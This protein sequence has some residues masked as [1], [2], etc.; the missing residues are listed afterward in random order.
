[1][2]AQDRF[3]VRVYDGIP[4]LGEFE[5]GEQALVF[6][7][8]DDEIWVPFF[9]LHQVHLHEVLSVLHRV[10]KYVNALPFED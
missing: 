9:S 8:L 7:F 10:E 5:P 1:M 6:E 2:Y 4:S 3:R